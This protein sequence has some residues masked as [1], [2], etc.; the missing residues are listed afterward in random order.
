MAKKKKVE[1]VV[2]VYTPE[3]EA[4]IQQDYDAMT[5]EEKEQLQDPSLLVKKES[6]K[7]TLARM[8]AENI[9]NV[10]TKELCK[11]IMLEVYPSVEKVRKDRGPTIA[12]LIVS[13]MLENSENPQFTDEE[14]VEIVQQD[15][16]GKKADKKHVAYYRSAINAAIKDVAK[17]RHLNLLPVDETGK[18]DLSV[19][20]LV[21]VQLN[22]RGEKVI[23]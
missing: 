2:E 21:K 9:D 7:Q 1:E 11:Q 10:L 17:A 13:I 15:F 23:V 5:P 16:P 20:P 3:Q 6:R 8:L 19:L 4:Q 14:I 12:H 18:P 22:S